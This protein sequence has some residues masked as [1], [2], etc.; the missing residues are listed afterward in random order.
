MHASPHVSIVMPVYNDDAW[1]A[2]A[3]D[4]CLTQTL[5]G[6]EIICVDDA[7]S[8]GT[9][10]I[11]REYQER[12]SRI[13]LIRQEENV[14]AFHARRI[15]AE[16]AEAPYILFLDGDDELEPEA[17]EVA[18]RH[19]AD[20]GADVVGFGVS[21]IGLHGKP[22]GGYQKRLRPPRKELE[23]AEI[24]E[25]LFPAGKATQGQL[26]RFMFS[27]DLIRNAY[28]K[29]TA[30][31]QLTRVNDLPLA[32]TAMALA[33]KYS[34][35]DAAL[36]RYYFQ[37]GGSGHK[38]AGLSDFEF[39]ARG[40]DSVTAMEPVVRRLA[41]RSPEP[42]GLL[43]AYDT[44]R[45][46]IIGNVLMY[47]HRSADETLHEECLEH[48]LG[49][50][51]ETDVIRAA[52]Y[53]APEASDILVQHGGHIPLKGRS[54]KSVLLTTKKITTGGVSLVVL[55][56]AKYLQQLGYQVTIAAMRSGNETSQIPE[57]VTFVEISAPTQSA[58][59][60]QWRSLCESQGVDVVVD[61]YVLYSR[62]WP[63]YA[64]MARALEI[65]TVGWVHSFA[66]RPVYNLRNMIS[67]IQKNSVILS[68]LI[69]LSPLDVAFWKMRGLRNVHFIPNP[70]SPMLR[71][72]A[73]RTSAKEAPEGRPVE[74]VWWGR[75]EQ[76]TKRVKDLIEVAAQLKRL[77]VDFRFKIIGP[78]SAD[79]TLEDLQTLAERRGV[80][81]QVEL[82]GPL[83]G[84]DL[85][86]VIDASD[87]FVSASIIEGYQLTLAEAQSRG[88]PVVMYDLP[89][90]SLLQNNEGALRVLQGD[91][92]AMARRIKELSEDIS[93]FESTSRASAEAADQALAPDF[94]SLYEQVLTDDLPAERSPE[95]T[96][97]D[98]QQIM[99]LML[100]YTE[101]NSGVR[102]QL[103]EAEQRGA[104]AR[105]R[106]T[107]AKE[108]AAPL[109]E[110]LTR[111]KFKWSRAEERLTRQKQVT[112][113]MERQK[114]AAERKAKRLR[115]AAKKS[116]KAQ[117]Q[118]APAANG[119]SAEAAPIVAKPPKK[120]DSALVK[121]LTPT[122]RRVY[123]VAP[124]VRPY[125][126]K[127]RRTL[128]P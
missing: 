57:G 4:S 49:K 100:F 55:A 38:V 111:A 30:D 102:E 12:D 29:F 82:I 3:L 18:S 126:R 52:A 17:A 51:P 2:A 54:V 91:V 47:L 112:A 56:Q 25:T 124:G 89:W 117:P 78:D 101:S 59:L 31:L 15:G 60:E 73:G 123:K 106:L 83:H 53:F 110:R 127:V 26:W 33:T 63:L 1:I 8:D 10:R 42:W 39:Y 34:Y 48:L 119:R 46:A 96:F 121:A 35:V 6:V 99:D 40:I 62:N 122:L 66:L 27:S 9:P 98:A 115:T 80:E 109:E 5:E 69:A 120:E 103:E 45:L 22:V 68:S 41:Y 90:L 19:A 28:A 13:R 58:R 7:S 72:A 14:A 88:L 118:P 61:H 107:R 74:L 16:A 24:L 104:A 11:I 21:V 64:A 65:P 23:G 84:Q 93:L 114:E 108:R 43:D 50:V 116:K 95:P 94:V 70:P 71:E 125:A 75:F 37:R 36:Y 67:F 77:D 86:D 113:D 20:V 128:K 105:T 79:I 85:L 97:E 76:R 87:I 32:F 44:A 92:A 81:N